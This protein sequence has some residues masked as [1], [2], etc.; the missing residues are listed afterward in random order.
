VSRAPAKKFEAGDVSRRETSQ[1]KFFVPALKPGP[2]QPEEPRTPGKT[3]ANHAVIIYN[4][5]TLIHIDK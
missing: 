4:N 3:P 2:G 5:I 1:K